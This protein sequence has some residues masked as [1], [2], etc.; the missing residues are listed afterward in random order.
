MKDK[1]K[2][3][4]KSEELDSVKAQLAKKD[5]EIAKAKS[6]CEHWKNDYYRVYADM[7][8]LR[9]EI[10]RDHQ[11]VIKYRVEGFVDKLISVLDAFDMAFKVEP[12]TVELKNYLQGFKYVH[13]QLV[14]LLNDEGV[15]IINPPIIPNSVKRQCKLFKLSKMMVKNIL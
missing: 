14:S 12:T 7:A 2:K 10:E 15:E 6:D 9:K 13:T 8:N 5:E 4:E 1:E 3:E 11:D